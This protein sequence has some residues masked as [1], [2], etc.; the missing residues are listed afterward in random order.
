[1]SEK[2]SISNG[3][4]QKLKENEILYLGAILF[5]ICA[6]TGLLLGVVYES[7]KD[8]IS[9]KKQAVSQTAYEKVLPEGAPETMD[10]VEIPEAYHNDIAE[11][12]KAGDAGYAI[13][14]IGKGYAGDDIE[15]A[16]G[17]TTE[18]MISGVTI[19]SHA[20]TPGLGAK[21]TESSF[22]VQYKGVATDQ[23]LT[24]V[25]TEGTLPHEID[26]ISG[27]TK[28]T[29]GVTNAVNRVCAFYEECLKGGE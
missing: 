23:V 24:V 6:V 18:G 4:I 13:K 25:K 2:K 20:E 17:I 22:L 9:D 11:A 1:M 28:T 16:V 27:A 19:I 21:A 29:I 10:V 14:I 8:V 26:A 12:Y 7:T 15:I 5:F 3:F